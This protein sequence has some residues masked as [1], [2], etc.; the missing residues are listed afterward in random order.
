MP[1]K[2]KTKSKETAVGDAAPSSSGVDFKI[3]GLTIAV[4]ISFLFFGFALENLTRT[5]FGGEKF[6]GSN[7]LVCVQGFVST[8]LAAVFLLWNHGSKVSWGAGV[9]ITDWLIV[10]L[11]FVGAHLFGYSALRFISY[12]M[13]VIFKSCKLIPVMGGE[14]LFANVKPTMR[15]IVEG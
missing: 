11:G 12:P 9:P 5:K 13:Q 8:C 4:W 10:S 3:I 15:K 1:S 6:K 2:V 14:Y 7:T